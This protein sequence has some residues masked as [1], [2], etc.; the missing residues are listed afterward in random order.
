ML[1]VVISGLARG[2]AASSPKSTRKREAVRALGP[3]Q[4]SER[5][6]RW[7][8]IQP[9]REPRMNLTFSQS[10]LEAIAAALGDT[11]DGLTGTEIKHLLATARIEDVSPELAK[12][13]RL[14]NAFATSHNKLNHRRHVLAFIRFAMKPERHLANPAR[15][16]SMRTALNRALAFAGMAVESNGELVEVAEVR[17]IAEAERRAQDLRS[18]LLRRGAHPEVLAFCRAELLADNYFHAVLEATKSVADKLRRKA[19]D[20]GDGAALIDAALSSDTPILVINPFLS[21]SERSE[22]RGFANLIKGVFGMFRNV[23]AHQARIHWVLSKEDAEDLMSVA[24]L[25]HRR[26]DAAKRR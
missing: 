11:S 21:E 1:E 25:I 7:R 14:F 22:Q 8:S 3:V 10:Q 18:D 17:T 4:V 24:S 6:Y 26:L 15:F 2:L 19:A 20:T 9:N 12:R 23:T 16:E 13:H 5:T